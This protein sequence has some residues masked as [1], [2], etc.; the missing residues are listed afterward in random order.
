MCL[1]CSNKHM[2]QP[3]FQ[4]T[5]SCQLCAEQ[6]VMWA[7]HG[8]CL[9]CQNATFPTTCPAEHQS[10]PLANLYDCSHADVACMLHSCNAVWA[11]WGASR[12]LDTFSVNAPSAILLTSSA[13]R[14]FLQTRSVHYMMH[15][16]QTAD[17]KLQHDEHA[18]TPTPEQTGLNRCRSQE[19]CRTP[20]HTRNNHHSQMRAG[21]GPRAGNPPD[22][23]KHTPREKAACRAKATQHM[24]PIVYSMQ[25]QES[26][27]STQQEN[28]PTQTRCTWARPHALTQAASHCAGSGRGKAHMQSLQTVKRHDTA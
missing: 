10:H 5:T 21:P 28:P 26:H 17:P 9:A 22:Q 13:E 15:A 19:G 2:Q 20:A 14:L 4:P 11:F 7:T 24:L 16:S 23:T 18:T 8:P 1:R 25:A 27:P 6:L 12:P 3:A